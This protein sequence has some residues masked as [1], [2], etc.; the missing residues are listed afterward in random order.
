MAQ[1]VGEAPLLPSGQSSYALKTYP[2]SVTS[3]VPVARSQTLAGVMKCLTSS[4]AHCLAVYGC[5][6]KEAVKQAQ[7]PFQT[8]QASPDLPRPRSETPATPQDNLQHTQSA[9]TASL[10]LASCSRWRLQSSPRE[11]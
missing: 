1:E 9:R 7:R 2:A 11:D 3:S 8:T 5:H 4:T 10:A 6:D